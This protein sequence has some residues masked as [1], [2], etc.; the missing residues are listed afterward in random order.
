MSFSNPDLENST[1]EMSFSYDDD[2]D[3]FSDDDFDDDF[4][5]YDEEDESLDEFDDEDDLYYDDVFKEEEDID[6]P[7]DDVEEEDGYSRYV[8]DASEELMEDD[9]LNFDDDE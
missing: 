4:D 5:G 2:F 7:Y 6:E 3:D 1:M 9:E 8:H